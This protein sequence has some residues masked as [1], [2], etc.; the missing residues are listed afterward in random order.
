MA[1]RPPLRGHISPAQSTLWLIAAKTT[2]FALGLAVPLLLV[3]R[4]PVREFGVYKQLFLLVDTAVVILPLGFALS[5]FFFFPREPERKA[6]VVRN[7]LLV[8]MFMGAIGG[9]LVSVFPALPAA[10]L[11][12]PDLAAY[13]PE[14]GLVMLLL[15]GS[16]FVEFVAIANGEAHLAAL[17]IGVSQVLRSGLFITAASLFGSVRALAYAAVVHGFLQCALMAWYVRDFLQRAGRPSGAWCGHNSPTRCRWRTP[18]SSGGCRGG[19][20]TTLCRTGTMRQCT[21][22]TRWAV[23]R[24]RSWASWWSRSGMWQFAGRANCGS[25]TRHGRSS[26]SRHNRCAPWPRSHSPSTPCCW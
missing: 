4:L 6:Q 20:T 3:R 11:S 22:C 21:P 7:I 16:S 19:C 17:F 26:A 8:H 9:V 13:A 2:V 25:E 14:I 24:F 1:S 23:F 10:L 15:V 18:G 5:A 12:S